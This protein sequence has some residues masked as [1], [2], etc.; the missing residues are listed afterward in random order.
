MED[1]DD[2][3]R[4]ETFWQALIA[5]IPRALWPDK[6]GVAGS[7]NLVSEYTGIQFAAGTSVGIGQVMEFYINFGT[8]GVV[9]GFIIFGL[10]VTIC[11]TCAGERLASGDLYGFVLWYMP[12]LSMLQVGGSLAEITSSVAASVFVALMVNKYL[13]R[14][15][16]KK[17]DE[18]ALLR[19]ALASST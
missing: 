18:A 17:A 14:V 3:A 11:D 9:F 6:P 19:P 4:G 1:T 7:G 8:F 16:H 10:V 5:L 12:G 2:F 15:Q 13:S